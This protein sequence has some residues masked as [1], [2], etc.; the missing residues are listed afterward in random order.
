MPKTK[1]FFNPR[2]IPMKSRWPEWF[3]ATES[4]DSFIRNYFDTVFMYW[5][6]R[7]PSPHTGL[8]TASTNHFYGT[9]REPSKAEE[10]NV[11]KF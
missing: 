7:K 4:G 8:K 2:Q 9:N 3:M 6:F 10:N 1:Q 5:S 11:V